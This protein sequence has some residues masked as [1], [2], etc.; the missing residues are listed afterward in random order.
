MVESGA[1]VPLMG[2][3]HMI[4]R[5]CR[6]TL[7]RLDGRQVEGLVSHIQATFRDG[8]PRALQDKYDIPDPDP[9]SWEIPAG[10]ILE[11]CD[12]WLEGYSKEQ[13]WTV[14]AFMLLDLAA[15]QWKPPK[16]PDSLTADGWQRDHAGNLLAASENDAAESTEVVS[17]PGRLTNFGSSIAFLPEGERG[18]WPI[19]DEP[20]MRFHNVL[21]LASEA[22]SCVTLL[23]GQIDATVA[24]NESM[25]NQQQKAAKGR[26]EQIRE[27]GEETRRRV[28]K[29]REGMRAQGRPE[30]NIAGTLALRADM[31]S[32]G[33]IRAI[34]REEDHK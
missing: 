7:E 27:K 9:E 16:L 29:A 21:H 28:L 31:P 24:A 4:R 8:W 11:V 18:F 6:S 15:G 22:W 2:T 26:G 25:R 10:L 34:F 13:H 19:T 33:R 1:L 30:R 20:T 14:L 32:E 17:L 23:Q 5:F 12:S 3:P